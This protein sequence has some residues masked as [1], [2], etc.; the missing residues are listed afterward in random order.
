MSSL[1]HKK[2]DKD[3]SSASKSSVMSKLPVPPPPIVKLPNSPSTS[4]QSLSS[5]SSSINV[6]KNTG[7]ASSSGNFSTTG[8]SSPTTSASSPVLGQPSLQGST[9]TT[10]TSLSSS[11]T[12]ISHHNSSSSSNKPVEEIKKNSLG[13]SGGMKGSGSPYSRASTILSNHSNNSDSSPPSSLFSTS[14]S[15]TNESLVYQDNDSSM[16]PNTKMGNFI[17]GL[18]VTTGGEQPRS[19]HSASL[20]EDT[21][22]VF[23]GEG[24]DNNPTND[25]FS[26]NFSTK[27]WASI[28]NSN[29]PSPRSYHS[30]L[31]YNNALYIF[32]GEGGN[33]SKNDLFVYSFDTQLWSEI[34][35]SDTNRPPARC[36]HSAVID[37][38]TMVIF[39]GISGNK[40]TNEVYAFSFETKTWSVVSTTNTPTAR[41]FHTVSVHK[42]IMYTIGGQ[43][44]S[45]NALDDIHCLTLATKEWR[46][47]QVVEGSPFPARSHHSATLL[48]DSIIVTGG[49][50][51]KPHSTLDVYELDLY[52]K[53]WFKIQTTSQGANRISH[54][55]ILKGLSLFL[56]G[57]S[58]DTSL[59]YFSFG[60]N[61]EFE[62]LIQEEDGEVSRLQ[63]IPKAFWEST[64]MKKHP[65]ILDLRERTQLLTGVKS[66]G[67]SLASPSFTENKTAVSHQFVLQLIMEYLERHRQYHKT[68]QV[69]EK[70]SG[71][72]HQMTESGESRLVTILRLVKPRLR[73]KYV[74]DQD[75]HIFPKQEAFDEEVQ[76]VDNLYRR[77]ESEEDANVWDEPEDGPKNIRK[78]EG[79]LSAADKQR[80]EALDPIKKRVCDVIKFWI[81]KCPWDFKTGPNADKLVASLNNFIDGALTRDGNASV[82]NLR[83]I[84]AQARTAETSQS[85]MV[86]STNPPE[87]KVPK[88]IF[89]PQLTLSH[90]DE[91]EIARQLTLIE[92][93]IFRNIPPPEF[94]VRVTPFGEF[95]YS[96]ATAPN[97]ILFL[98]RSSDVSKWVAY[99]ILSQD[100]KKSRAKMIDK[101]VKIMECLRTLN[102]FQTLYSIYLGLQNSAVQ[103]VHDIFSVRAK[104]V[105]MEHE[106]L[107]SKGENY[108]NY[109]E[110]LSKSSLPCIPLVHVIQED[111]AFIEKEQPGMTNVL[112]NFVKRQNLY[113]IISKAEAYQVHSYNLQPVHQVSTFINKLPRIN[114]LDLVELSKKELI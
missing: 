99:T 86:Y 60:K 68:I 103:S 4:S 8:A 108:R 55:S 100:Q 23:G 51:V 101:Y 2:E 14:S 26:F 18:K 106:S 46:P 3:K 16:D 32:G 38:Q 105:L 44:T 104:E 93:K 53:K 94:L 20:Y 113:N 70:E 22:Y 41:A 102:N 91:L 35:V 13:G 12:G 81:D 82:K 88:N 5:S 42:G 78:T 89:S 52:Q 24:I 61:D 76:V 39:G 47:F 33:S 34:N 67:K 83:R 107:F 90:I 77:V 72:V 111:I 114:D 11:M 112:I 96:M 36:G 54:T 48:Q 7:G 25:F 109:R 74:L 40:P 66:Y 50:S 69:I 56:Y 92:Y 27:T 28:S 87:P 110:V 64:L 31:I 6:A 10:N 37:G 43:D 73:S 85:S 49:A 29:G 45:T 17:G 97:L 9:S 71:V 62:D 19:G 63:N 98:N 30:S 58:Q 80:L 1:F 57:G 15:P 84:L 95:Q 75:L 21:F 59:D 65:E 79:P